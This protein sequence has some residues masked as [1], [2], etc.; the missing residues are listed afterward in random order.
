MTFGPSE[1]L[2][3]LPRYAVILAISAA[4]LTLFITG[5][6]LHALAAPPLRQAPS[7]R[8]ALAIGGSFAPSQRFSGFVD[9]NSG[10]AFVLMEFPAEA[11][12][13]IRQLGDNPA[14]LTAQGLSDIHKAELKGRKGD[15]VFITGAQ[16]TP[17]LNYAKFI[18]IFRENGITGMIT[19][20]VPE[21][22]L[23]TGKITASQIEA[24]LTSAT[25]KS[26]PAPAAI[27]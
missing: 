3:A 22:A 8:I 17:L 18:L 19:G 5:I 20:N 26:Q 24:I 25:V 13:Q 1:D 4:A 9:E 10:A 6:F 11:F 14:A 16:K 7:S 23:Q 12:E 15:Y 21:A 27:C 2:L